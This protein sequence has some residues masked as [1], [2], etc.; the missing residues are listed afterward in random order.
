M[1]ED[2]GQSQEGAAGLRETGQSGSWI[3]R[4]L[5]SRRDEDEGAGGREDKRARWENGQL[6]PEFHQAKKTPGRGQH[7]RQRG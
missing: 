1:G 4:T 5:R 7:G 6:V 2:R 3:F